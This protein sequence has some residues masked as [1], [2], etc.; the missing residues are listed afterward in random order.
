MRLNILELDDFFW[1]VNDSS[2][3]FADPISPL[4]ASVHNSILVQ[5]PTFLSNDEAADFLRLSLRTLEKLRVVGGGPPFRKFRRRVF[6]ALEDLQK[7]A[8]CRAFDTT[9]DPHYQRYGV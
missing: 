2:A 6:Y 5:N 7:W 4:G 1:I 3:I 8:A 9:G